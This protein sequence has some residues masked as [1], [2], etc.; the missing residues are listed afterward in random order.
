MHYSSGTCLFNLNCYILCCM[1]N[2]AKK[3]F[4]FRGTSVVQTII[5]ECTVQYNSSKASKKLMLQIK[6]K[7]SK[8]F[9]KQ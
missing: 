3:I 1:L 4:F 2:T 9:L 6:E 7:F 8:L 5:R